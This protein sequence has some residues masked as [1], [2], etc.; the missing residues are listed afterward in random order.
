MDAREF[1]DNVDRSGGP[2]ACWPWLR[3]VKPN[4]YGA[5]HFDG[6][7]RLAHR[8]AYTL[9]RGDIPAGA[10]LDHTCRPPGGSE[11]VKRCCN[12]AHLEPITQAE[13]VVRAA[14]QDRTQRTHCRRGH[15]LTPENLWQPSPM[16]RECLTCRRDGNR[17]AAARSRA[18]KRD[19]AMLHP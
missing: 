9:T 1:W 8:V 11:D 18:R 7:T 4:G 17:A 19:N 5:V 3:F 15:E 13:N 10:V 16:R 12:P 6:C 14:I 2:E